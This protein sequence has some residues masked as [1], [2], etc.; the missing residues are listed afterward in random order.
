MWLLLIILS[1]AVLAAIKTLKVSTFPP[2][3]LATL[4]T[5]R[6]LVVLYN[7]DFCIEGDGLAESL[8]NKALY[9]F[10]PTDRAFAALT[11]GT[12]NRL[13][14]PENRETLTRILTYHLIRGEVTARNSSWRSENGGSP[15]NVKE[16]CYQSSQG[17]RCE[18]D[19]A[20]H[21]SEQR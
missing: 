21:A 16:F 5:L 6:R 10:R 7:A 20:E 17:E 12:L 3:R 14:L 11:K 15:V 13:L 9:S 19:P 18:C 2:R 4:L 1:V 8:Q